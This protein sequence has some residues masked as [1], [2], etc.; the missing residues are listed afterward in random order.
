[1]SFSND[2]NSDDDAEDDSD[3]CSEELGWGSYFVDF[4]R[5]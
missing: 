3:V 1:M 5:C 4:Y 2:C